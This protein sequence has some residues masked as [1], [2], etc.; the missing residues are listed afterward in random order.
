MA[1][2]DGAQTLGAHFRTVLRSEI[3]A[4]HLSPGSRLQ[5]GVLARK[6]GTSTTVIR[7][8]LTQLVTDRLVLARPNQGYYVVRL[9]LTELEDLTLVRCHNDTLALRL[10]IERG[11]LA[12]ETEIMS[13]FHVLSRTPRRSPEDPTHTTGEWAAAHRTYHLKLLS[14]CGIEI[15]LD[16]SQTCFDA[17]ELHRRWAAPSPSATKRNPDDEH[18]AILDACLA[19][20]ADQACALLEH[21]YRTTLGVVLEAGLSAQPD[22]EVT[23]E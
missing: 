23:A 12:W 21:H 10:A 11:D 1:Q 13:A 15:L 8:V 6:Y 5:P 4:G 7:E 14:A 17:T 19:R 22:S 18:R 9:S 20:D 2:R 3:L 16:V